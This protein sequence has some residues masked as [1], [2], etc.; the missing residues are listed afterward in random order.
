MID[1]DVVQQV[2]NFVKTETGVNNSPTLT[3]RELSTAISATD[4]DVLLLGGLVE[5]KDT[6]TSSGLPFLP[7]FLASSTSDV[8]KS[9]LLLVLQ[10]RKQ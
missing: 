2:S 5:E 1:L 4:G 10:V 8:S 6:A 3:K 9:K 7:S